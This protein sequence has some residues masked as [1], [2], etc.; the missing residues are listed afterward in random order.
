LEDD[1][2]SPPEGE[3]AQGGLP[4]DPLFFRDIFQPYQE[5]SQIRGM[6]ERLGRK[7]EKLE[8][9]RAIVCFYEDF[10]RADIPSFETCQTLR[11]GRII[12]VKTS[13]KF[14]SIVKLLYTLKKKGNAR[15]SK[16]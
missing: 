6:P 3:A 13:F 9:P 12:Q 10:N 8:P 7:H 16:Y 1:P 11:N 2:L 15:A 4:L 5:L 14:C